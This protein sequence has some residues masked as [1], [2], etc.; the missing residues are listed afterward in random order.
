M[1]M[2]QSTQVPRNEAHQVIAE[3]QAARVQV[4]VRAMLSRLSSAV[5]VREEQRPTDVERQLADRRENCSRATRPELGTVQS[6]PIQRVGTDPCL[7][8]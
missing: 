5:A 6:E 2:R 1:M 4:H 7:S 3:A 8:D